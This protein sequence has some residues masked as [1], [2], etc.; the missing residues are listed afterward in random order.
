MIRIDTHTAVVFLAGLD[1][2][3]VK[4]AV[5]FPFLD[6]STLDKR[7]SACEA[8]VA[9]NRRYAPRHLPRRRSDHARRRSGLRIGGSGEPVEWAVHMRRFDETRTLDHVAERGELDDAA[10]HAGSSSCFSR[11]IAMRRSRDGARQPRRSAGVV[12]ETLTE[13]AAAP[14]CSSR[15]RDGG[16]RRGD[17]AAFG[18][19]GRFS[20]SAAPAG[21][22]RRCH[23]DLHLR[24]I[25]LL[26]GVPTPF[27]AIEFD[28]SIATIDILYDLAF[29]LMDLWETRAAGAGKPG[30]QPLSLGIAGPR[31]EL[32]GL[33]ALPL[34]M[35]L[36]AAVRAK[37]DA[38]R[39][40]E[41]ERAASDAGEA[42]RYF[43][44]AASLPEPVA[45]ATGGDRRAVGHRQDD[46]CSAGSPRAIGRAPGAVHLRSD[47][48]RKRL[49]GVAEHSRLPEAAYAPAGDGAGLRGSPR[50]GRRWR[51]AAGQSVIVDAVHRRPEE[52]DAIAAVAARLRVPFTGVWLDAPLDIA[53]E[54]VA[55]R[56]DDASDAT[57][58][59][60]ARQAAQPTGPISWARIDSLGQ[61]RRCRVGGPCQR[62][63]EAGKLRGERPSPPG[64][65]AREAERCVAELG[66]ELVRHLD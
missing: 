34:F 36:R 15:E 9:V 63:T 22:V 18:G 57:A 53:V 65:P 21:C 20:S 61:R 39:L 11:P 40:R 17:A 10:D 48:E 47:I 3:K 28:E 62:S 1:V 8:E 4:R 66:G 16:A 12:E 26:N 41:V 7:R 19:S 43:A 60:V 56:R 6:Q 44:F 31:G 29:L 33:A 54:R 30:A 5:R 46:D 27:D 45:A 50:P 52:R 38:L 37:V 51:F 2:Y 42:R 13:L 23:G 64:D 49:F 59:I 35:S 25:A 58:A 32:E 24:N 14:T 55:A